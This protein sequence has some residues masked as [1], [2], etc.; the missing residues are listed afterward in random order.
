M[1]ITYLPDM[2]KEHIII[3]HPS[4]GSV[5]VGATLAQGWNLTA[6]QGTAGSKAAD[7]VAAIGGLWEYCICSKATG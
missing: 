1:S 3:P 5:T 6:L 7:M 2:R 4:M